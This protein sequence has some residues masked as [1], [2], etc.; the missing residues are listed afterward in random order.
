VIAGFSLATTQAAS[1][2]PTEQPTD[3]SETPTATQEPTSDPSGEPSD[4][5]PIDPTDDG[6]VQSDRLGGDT[7][8]ETAVEIS[9]EAF[10]AGS[11]DVFL[12][13]ADEFPDA[14]AAGSLTTGPILLVPQCGEIPQVVLDEIER[15]SP[16][17]VVALGG[18]DA[19]CEQVLQEATEAASGADSTPSPSESPSPSETASEPQ[20]PDCEAD[21][22]NPDCLFP[23]ETETAAPS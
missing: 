8:F 5:L 10:P 2:Q 17:R 1:S 21:P 14:L 23:T 13:R 19:V 11:V 20:T 6:E 15:L 4:L 9:M 3:P 22:L 16:E 7:R 12:A 18:V